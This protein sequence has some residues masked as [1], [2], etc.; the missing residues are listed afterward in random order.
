VAHVRDLAGLPIR[1]PKTT[2]FL[3]ALIAAVAVVGLTRL[4]EEENLLVFLPTDDPDVVLFREVAHRFGGMRVALIGVEAPHGQDLFTPGSLAKLRAAT[5]AIKNVQGVDRVMSMTNT[6]DVQAGPMGAEVAPLIADLPASDAEAGALR[7]KV[8]SRDHLVG[9]VVSKDGRAA[10]ILVF[11]TDG[12]GD[13]AVTHALKQAAGAALAPLTVYYGGAPFAGATIYEE[14]QADV[15]RLSPLAM[16]V[17]LLVVVL[18]FRDPVG[19]VLTVAS[20]AFSVLVVLG[21]MGFFHDKFTIASSALPVILFASGSSY[22]VHVLGRYYLLREREDAPAAMRGALSI[23]GPPLLIAAGTT[24][25]GFY[26]FVATDV[27]PMRAFGIAC[28]SGVLL[29]WLTS[30]TLVPAVVALWPRQ[31]RPQRTVG[32]IGDWLV[33][34]WGWARRRRALVVAGAVGLV[35]LLV[36]P[37]TRVTVRMDPSSF[38]RPGSDP[39]RAERF[40]DEKF[41]GAHFVQIAV[42]ADLGDPASLRQLQGLVDYTRS[43]PGVTQV[44]AITQPLLLVNDVM[45]GG[46]R[47]PATPAQASNLYFFL[48]GQAGLSQLM[49]ADRKEGLLQVRVRGDARPV[50][51]ALEAMVT[52]LPA[53]PRLPGRDQVADRV[54][55]LIRS[56]T[57]HDVPDRAR[58]RHVVGLV[59]APG[60]D[61]VGYAARRVEL[62]RAF[63]AGEEAPPIAA[64]RR[65]VLVKLIDNHAPLAQLEVALTAAAPSPEE[66]K[67]AWQMLSGRLSDERRTLAVDRALPAVLEAAGVHVT[68]GA[69]DPD[70]GPALEAALR[71]TLDDLFLPEAAVAHPTV[72]FSARV[73]GEPILDR[74]FSR[75][76]ERNQIR[77]LLISIVAVFVMLIALFR[78]TV[79]A[80]VCMFPSLLTMVV[81]FGVMGLWQLHIDLGTSLVAGIATGAGSDFAMHY[82]WYLRREPADHVSR[83]VGPVM[84]V[85]ILLVSFGFIVLALGRSPVMNLFGWLAGLSMSVSALFTCLL[86][87][88]LLNKFG[89]GEGPTSTGGGST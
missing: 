58:L 6:P 21:G 7:A 5:A 56:V 31:A 34:L 14:A 85:S 23:V 52:R 49:T 78:S 38:F 73:A 89:A 53:Q 51:D 47:L 54:A 66:G 24:A 69:I 17:L 50:V 40:L 77:S 10:L 75:S 16:L 13:R 59:A 12:V 29:C 11:L 42:K 45:G 68:D 39:Y 37:M 88:A 35:L 55:W 8:L 20:V 46:R 36:V 15:A 64:D 62:G 70:L 74:G 67:L 26:S 2:V 19:V 28:G 87:P 30:L 32:L 72:P 9:N 41:G 71:P 57:G 4:K 27:R 33:W 82:L 25:V 80:A 1:W 61:D 76:V 83:S 18:S 60:D 86:V 81:I 43:L 65:D 79:V 84:V 48:E 63:L 3:F 44:N 22:A